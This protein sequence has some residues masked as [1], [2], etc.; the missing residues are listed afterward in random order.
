MTS[1]LVIDVT[2]VMQPNA[3]AITLTQHG[4]S[5]QRIGLDMMAF[6]PD[7]DLTVRAT[8]TPIGGAVMVQAD[9]DG[10]LTGQCSRCLNTLTPDH[11]VSLSE[12]FYADAESTFVGSE[13]DSLSDDDDENDAHVGRIEHGRI[14][15][16]DA[17]VNEVGVVLPFNPVC[18]DYGRECTNDDVPA[19]DGVSGEEH[20]SR[21]DPRWAGLEK[22]R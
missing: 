11:E 15:L 2:G 4:V 14:D 12:V 5:G 19:P 6:A 16:T 1:P 17:F 21:I 18:E 13:D 20:A 7:T 22:F 9:I 8:L 10:T 3:D